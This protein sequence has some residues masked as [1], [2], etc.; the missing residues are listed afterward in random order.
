[1]IL[2]CVILGLACT[3]LAVAAQAL[4]KQGPPSEQIAPG[5][6]QIIPRG[7]I[8]SIDEPKFVS[9]DKAKIG[10]DSWVLG[11]E[12]DGQVRAYSLSLLNHHEVV[13][14]VVAEKPIAAVW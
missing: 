13:N 14:D 11:I 4:Q 1:M 6:E 9:A 8:A 3:V 10:D 2:K 7:R 5:F 12:L